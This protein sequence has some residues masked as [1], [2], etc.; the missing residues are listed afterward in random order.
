MKQSLVI[1]AGITLLASPTFANPIA[2]EVLRARA[3]PGPHVQLSYGV[4]TA[5]TGSDPV[6]PSKVTTHGSVYTLWADPVGY[7]TNTGSGVVPVMARQM[8]DC[9]V[10]N[11]TTLR[12]EITVGDS[13]GQTRTLLADATTPGRMDAAT[14]PADPDGGV[15][16]WDIP[17][18]TEVQGI[19][20]TAVCAA[21][22]SGVDAAITVDA[23]PIVVPDGGL[24]INLDAPALVTVDASQLIS[25]A[26]PNPIDVPFVHLMDAGALADGAVI[27]APDTG[28]AKSDAVAADAA[29]ARDAGLPGAIDGGAVATNTGTSVNTGTNTNTNTS[30]ETVGEGG[31]CSC[32]IGQR[33]RSTGLGFL[34]F[35]GAVL[36]LIRRRRA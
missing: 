22:Q 33:G 26:G 23:A 18:P 25:E 15:L 11:D 19:D 4:D 24:I 6:T 12:Y 21:M 27:A 36:A 10:P 34:V 8:C 7:R 14:A 30:S 29:A 28:P 32:S 2:T 5:H 1:V 20:C 31:G 17:D 9:F 3:V 35:F 16:P 13:V